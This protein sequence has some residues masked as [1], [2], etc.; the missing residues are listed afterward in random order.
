MMGTQ[1]MACQTC[2]GH[3]QR[4]LQGNEKIRIKPEWCCETLG[5]TVSHISSPEV[6]VC[7]TKSVDEEA[8]CAGTTSQVL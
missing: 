7:P 3:N 4:P 2:E 8:C 1:K 5:T 6:S